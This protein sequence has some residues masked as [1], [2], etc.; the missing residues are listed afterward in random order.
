MVVEHHRLDHLRVDHARYNLP[1]LLRIVDRARQRNLPI[2]FLRTPHH[3]SYVEHR[4]PEWEAQFQAMVQAVQH[5]AGP[6]LVKVLDWERH[7]AFRHEHF[8]DGDHL[9]ASGVVLLRDLLEPILRE[10]TEDRRLMTKDDG[11]R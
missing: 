6:G 10:M 3:A 2:V 5:H 9:N 11:Q 7:P 4:P 8:A 1:A